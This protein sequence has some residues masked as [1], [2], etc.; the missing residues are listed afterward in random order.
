MD[1]KIAMKD[2]GED[3]KQIA[4][5]LLETEQNVE[6]RIG[7]RAQAAAAD[8]RDKA[9]EVVGEIKVRSRAPPLSL[10]AHRCQRFSRG[11]S[12]ADYLF[13]G[14]GKRCLGNIMALQRCRIEDSPC[15]DVQRPLRTSGPRRMNFAHCRADKYLHLFLDNCPDCLQT[16][17]QGQARETS[18]GVRKEA[19]SAQASASSSAKQVHTAHVVSKCT[20]CRC[21]ACNSTF[22]K[23][24]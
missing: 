8:V 9:K 6:S 17:R 13:L 22:K 5:T 23:V 2:A 10:T 1:E 16:L 20:V 11:L 3:L 15:I 24:E 19:Q 18:A 12:H 4:A 14:K 7:A 21:V